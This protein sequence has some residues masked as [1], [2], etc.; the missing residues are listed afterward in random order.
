[1][2]GAEALNV[3]LPSFEGPLDLLFYLIRK[4][5]LE[6]SEVS[7]AVIADEFIAHLEAVEEFNLVVAGDFLV[8][9]ATLM[10][11]KSKWLLPPEETPEEAGEEDQVGPLLRRLAD[12]EKLREVVQTLN[13]FEDRSRASFSRPLTDE[14][15]RRLEHMAEN[16]PFLDLSAFELL[17]VM[18]RLQEFAFPVL[19]EI[20]RDEVKLEDKIAE[21]LALLKAGLKVS[22]SQLISSSR[23][24]IEA[25]VFFLAAL[26]LTRQKAIKLGQ[27][28]NFGE[29]FAQLRKH[30][31]GAA[32]RDEA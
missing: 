2:T 29:I 19:R 15:E 22:L 4:H 25:V 28:E 1:V 21:L 14:L 32:A 6:I 9:A 12:Y 18:K 7:L 31:A 20:V 8:I 10:Y 3:R 27:A 26:E 24:T 16:E 30:Q 5:E 17:K 11:L 13:R 23:S